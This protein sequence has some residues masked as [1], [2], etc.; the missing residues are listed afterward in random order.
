ML[1]PDPSRPRQIYPDYTKVDLRAGARRD[2]WT[3]NLFATNVFNKRG[4][5]AGGIG[6]A[7][8]TSLNYIQPRAYGMSVT[9]TF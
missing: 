2:D 4:A 9:K 7:F 3:V 6:D 8:S 5:V 1:S